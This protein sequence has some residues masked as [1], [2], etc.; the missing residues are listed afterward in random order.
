ME[1]ALKAQ[2][3]LVALPF[4]E[5]SFHAPSLGLESLH[6]GERFAGFEDK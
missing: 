5:L 2:D 6:P 1:E 4:S 3:V